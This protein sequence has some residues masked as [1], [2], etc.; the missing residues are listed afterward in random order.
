MLNLDF[1]SVFIDQKEP[2]KFD[3]VS[4]NQL[5]EIRIL[6]NAIKQNKMELILDKKKSLKTKNILEEIN[7]VKTHFKNT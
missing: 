7:F 3:L 6:V 4:V 1:S 5:E 2:I